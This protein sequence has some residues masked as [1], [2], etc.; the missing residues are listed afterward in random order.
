[1]PAVATSQP[2]Q[3]SQALTQPEKA[4]SVG[5]AATIPDLG[6]GLHTWQAGTGTN[7]TTLI[8]FSQNVNG[9]TSFAPIP[10]PTPSGDA[11]VTGTDGVVTPTGADGSLI[12]TAAGTGTK[13]SS[14]GAAAT[15]RAVAGSVVG[16]GAFMAAFL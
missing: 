5:V 14:T 4:T 16:V 1:M 3:P 2:S 15:M 6:P 10:T 7:S 12:T 11:G 9:S 8:V 13:A